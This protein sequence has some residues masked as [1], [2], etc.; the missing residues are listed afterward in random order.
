MDYVVI[1]RE[2]LVMQEIRKNV[3]YKLI[4]AMVKLYNFTVLGFNASQR[5]NKIT[6]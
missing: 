2:V 1:D 5:A 3:K 4:L 6:M